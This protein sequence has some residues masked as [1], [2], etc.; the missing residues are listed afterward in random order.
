MKVR[1]KQTG[2][3]FKDGWLH[4]QE[5]IWKVIT[6]HDEQKEFMGF[7][8]EP[9]PEA[10][11]EDVSGNISVDQIIAGLINGTHRL[12]KDEIYRRV[13]TIGYVAGWAFRVERKV[14]G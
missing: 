2:E 13:P 6:E 12:V 5:Q 7:T 4:P 3:V 10:Q 1:H 8:C 9:I 11:W 14:G